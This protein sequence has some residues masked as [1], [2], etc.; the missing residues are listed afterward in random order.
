MRLIDLNR[1]AQVITVI[2]GLLT[3][4]KL[5]G[6]A[7]FQWLNSNRAYVENFLKPISNLIPPINLTSNFTNWIPSIPEFY[8]DNNIYFSD[9]AFLLSF[10]V[11]ILII[12][13]LV[14]ESASFFRSFLL[15]IG[16]GICF[17]LIYF[18]TSI[19]YSDIWIMINTII[20]IIIK[21]TLFSDKEVAKRPIKGDFSNWLLEVIFALLILI[22]LEFIL[23]IIYYL[24]IKFIIFIIIFMNMLI[25]WLG[26]ILKFVLAS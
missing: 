6:T 15:G 14:F 18:V 9:N 7:I 4:D 12:L 21:P 22:V 26:E 23:K 25:G 5:I 8:R 13:G 11:T 16:W 17:N 10:I 2:V 3:I 1:L 20:A 24:L 19:F